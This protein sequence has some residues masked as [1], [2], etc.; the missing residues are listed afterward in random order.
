MAVRE[1]KPCP[2]CTGLLTAVV[3]AVEERVVTMESCNGCDRRWWT[4]DGVVVDP[5]E[6]F[7]RKSA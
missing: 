7:G 5:V 6:I 4:T 2:V 1:I 3:I